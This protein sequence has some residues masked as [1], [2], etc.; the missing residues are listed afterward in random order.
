MYNVERKKKKWSKPYLKLTLWG[1]SVSIVDRTK[2][3]PEGGN[4]M[5][6]FSL[7]FS[8][9]ITCNTSP[10]SVP[11]KPAFFTIKSCSFSV[12]HSIRHVADSDLPVVTEPS[13]SNASVSMADMIS[14]RLDGSDCVLRPRS[15]SEIKLRRSDLAR[16]DL[17]LAGRRNERRQI[18][19]RNRLPGGLGLA[20][21]LLQRADAIGCWM[22]LF[23]LA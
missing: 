9:S 2:N 16:A 19:D 7:L 21:M 18:G 3:T 14:A 11:N 22:D 8:T 1:G 13:A 10:A 6:L 23:W 5:T 17:D 20:P 12:V 4:V 15:W